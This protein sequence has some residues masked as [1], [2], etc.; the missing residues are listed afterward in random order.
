MLPN[1]IKAKY[2][3]AFEVLK[4]NDIPE[5]LLNRFNKEGYYFYKDAQK[6]MI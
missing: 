3:K 4:G 1:A 6:M 2:Q 5:P